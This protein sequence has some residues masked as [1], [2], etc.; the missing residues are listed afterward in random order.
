[1]ANGRIRRFIL[2]TANPNPVADAAMGASGD[3]DPN[4]KWR[5]L[6]FAFATT[7]DFATS[8]AGG[9]AVIISS[10]EPNAPALLAVQLSPGGVQAATNMGGGT[11]PV[12][13]NGDNWSPWFDL[14]RKV[15]GQ[16]GILAT[17]FQKRLKSR[18]VDSITGGRYIF[19]FLV[20]SWD[21]SPE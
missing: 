13:V 16:R 6:G 8:N 20:E 14:S 12:G 10:D 11:T 17:A 21:G 9:T 15:S 7:A 2:H 19:N 1:M 4:E 3:L 5:I 18:P